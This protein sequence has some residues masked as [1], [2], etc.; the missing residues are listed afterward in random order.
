MVVEDIIIALKSLE[1]AQR[2]IDALQD[3]YDLKCDQLKESL[4]V[5]G[6]LRL[7]LSKHGVE[8]EN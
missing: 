3:L 6:E 2:E 7:L 4:L 8:H 5:N 1:E